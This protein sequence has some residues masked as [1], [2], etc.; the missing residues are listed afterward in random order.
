MERLADS[1]KRRSRE[2]RKGVIKEDKEE[3]SKKETRRKWGGLKK[4]KGTVDKTRE[5]KLE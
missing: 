4:S 2:G 1:N 3:G 5:R